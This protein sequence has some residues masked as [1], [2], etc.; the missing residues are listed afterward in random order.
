MKK[1]DKI[2]TM[3]FMKLSNSFEVTDKGEIKWKDKSIKEPTEK[4]ILKVFNSKEYQSAFS[5]TPVTMGS[6]FKV[7]NSVYV[8]LKEIDNNSIRSIRE[9]LCTQPD[10]PQFIK[11]HEKKAQEYRKKLPKSK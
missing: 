6:L 5:D 3:H 11:D 4:E 7:E 9:W 8:T 10:A 2:N 1:E